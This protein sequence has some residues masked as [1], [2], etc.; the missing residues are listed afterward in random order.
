MSG[1]TTFFDLIRHG[2]P[3]GGPMFRG[4]QDDPL[5]DTGW[6]QM[7]T[8]VSDEDSW[9]LVITSPLERCRDF[10]RTLAGQRQLP[11]QEEPR[12][13]EI[14]FGDWEGKTSEQIMANTPEALTGFWSDPVKHQPPGGEALADFN[15]RVTEAWRYWQKEAAG[16]RILVVCHGGVIRMILAEVLGIP[17]GRS[18]SAI[19]VP[20]A[21]RSRIRVDESEYGVLS[22]LQHHGR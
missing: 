21:C 18:F 16:K 8:A 1:T 9:D 4:S 22:C 6:Q 10:A 13:Q 2:E 15:N 17:L 5:S 19:A 11:L 14:G 12:L 7:N 3:A 20:Y